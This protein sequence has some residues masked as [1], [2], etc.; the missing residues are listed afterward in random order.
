MNLL[1][2]YK[3]NSPSTNHAIVK[4]F[5]RIA[6]DL[7]APGMFF[8]VSTLR[9][10]S[11]ILHDSTIASD[12]AFAELRAMCAHFISLLVDFFVK[13]PSS[14]VI[15]MLFPKSRLESQEMIRGRR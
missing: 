4:M 3:R 6:V 1:R 14:A 12:P 13:S 10:F 2:D 5:Y 9:I 7:K 15:F 8:Q 11:A